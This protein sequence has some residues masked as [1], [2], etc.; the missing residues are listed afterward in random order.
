M[1]GVRGVGG[2][3][4]GGSGGGGVW[5]VDGGLGA[6]DAGA[7][8]ILEGGGAGQWRRLLFGVSVRVDDWSFGWRGHDLGAFGA[9][10]Q[11]YMCRLRQQGLVRGR[12]DAQMRFCVARSSLGQVSW[13]GV[14]RFSIGSYWHQR[15]K[16]MIADQHG[17]I[18]LLPQV[19]MLLCWTWLLTCAIFA[20]P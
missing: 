15:R 12:R 4:V 19:P 2:A 16:G 10:R 6:V 1:V 8:V 3:A 17:N 11:C 9:V 5:V 20:F 7:G 14:R 18:Y 13:R